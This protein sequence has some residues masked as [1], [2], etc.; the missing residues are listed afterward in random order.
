MFTQFFEV[1]THILPTQYIREYPSATLDDQEATL[2]IHIKQ[3]V[4]RDRDNLQQNPVTII[5]GHA[6]AFAKVSAFR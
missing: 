3:Y 6:N 1:K 4:P 2:H 5:A